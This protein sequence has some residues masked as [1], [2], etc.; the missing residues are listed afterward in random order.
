MTAF[1]CALV[2]MLIHSYIAEHVET[3]PFILKYNPE[4]NFNNSIYNNNRLGKN[5]PNFERRD[6]W[7]HT[8]VTQP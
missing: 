2:S 1:N 3:V 5:R 6:Y 8:F 7:S 4:D